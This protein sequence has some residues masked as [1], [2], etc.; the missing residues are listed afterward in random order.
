MYAELRSPL[1]GFLQRGGRPGWLCVE[2]GYGQQQKTSDF[3]C[4]CVA[5]C[6]CFLLR[7]YGFRSFVLVSDMKIK[8]RNSLKIHG[9]HAVPLK[10]TG[11]RQLVKLQSPAVCLINT[12]LLT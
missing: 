3:P 12:Q 8:R 2:G 4:M 7:S 5:L 6:C 10:A 11:I 1:K 9:E